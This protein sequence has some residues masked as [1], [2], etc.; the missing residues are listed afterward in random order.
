[1]DDAADLKLYEL[2]SDDAFRNMDK[3]L[4]DVQKR[5]LGN[6]PLGNVRSVVGKGLKD[7][8]RSALDVGV[9]DTAARGWKT[10]PEFHE[11]SDPAKHRSG[12]IITTY[13]GAHSISSILHPVIELSVGGIATPVIRFDFDFEAAI[14][15]AELTIRNG[16]ILSVDRFECSLK[17]QLEYAGVPLE[18]PQKRKYQIHDVVR[19]NPPLQ[20]D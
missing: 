14:D 17:T 6:D 7:S 13:L 8:L 20:I 3:I 2:V 19:F 9:L 5:Q 10:A 16:A 1:M 12:E 4:R 11:Y 18:D 15:V